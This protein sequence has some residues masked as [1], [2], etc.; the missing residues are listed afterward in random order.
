MDYLQ[1]KS[2]RS[3]AAAITGFLRHSVRKIGITREK[4]PSCI[5]LAV[6]PLVTFYLFEM[7]THNPF[8]TMH[9]KTQLLNMAF[10]VLTALLLFGIVKYVRAALM[11]QTAFFMVVGLANY[12]VLNGMYYETYEKDIILA[13]MK[14]SIQNKQ[15]Q[16]VCGG[17]FQ[18]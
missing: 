8:T 5:A 7:Y 11:L 16:I 15:S 2:I 12:Y 10:Y 3:V 17:Q 18:L 13:K 14:E 9:F 1:K 4:L 6:C